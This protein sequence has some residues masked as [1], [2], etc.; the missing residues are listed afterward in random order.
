MKRDYEYEFRTVFPDVDVQVERTFGCRMLITGGNGVRSIR[1][2]ASWKEWFIRWRTP[3]GLWTCADGREVIFNRDYLPIR[4]RS[5]GEVKSAN[6]KEW[7]EWTG[8]RYFHDGDDRPRSALLKRLE[9]VLAEFNAGK[10]V[11]QYLDQE[12]PDRQK[13]PAGPASQR[14]PHD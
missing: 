10:D 13:P 9:K 14:A 4:E 8:Q 12:P 1:R 5:D 11:R 3:Y 2:H 6:H 7:V